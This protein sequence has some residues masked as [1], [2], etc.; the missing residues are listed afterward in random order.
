MNMNNLYLFSHKYQREWADELPYRPI[1]YPLS[2]WH[3]NLREQFIGKFYSQDRILKFKQPTL[4]IIHYYLIP[5]LFFIR[6][7]RW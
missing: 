7:A 3:G 6:E 4:P 5:S 1:C 2:M